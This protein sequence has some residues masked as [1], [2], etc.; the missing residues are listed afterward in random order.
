MEQKLQK[1][2]TMRRIAGHMIFCYNYVTN[3]FKEAVIENS[4]GRKR[5]VQEQNCV[6][7]QALNKK[8][9][10]RKLAKIGIIKLEQKK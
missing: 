4:F 6:Y 7:V 5:I 2:G 1:V 3:E 8:N 10:L 9:A